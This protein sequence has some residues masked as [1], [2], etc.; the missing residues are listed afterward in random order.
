MDYSYIPSYSN[1]NT[2]LADLLKSGKLMDYVEALKKDEFVVLRHDVE[3]SI[4]RAYIMAQIE[5]KVGVKSS[6]FIQITNN[7]Y[8]A[9]SGKNKGLIHEMREMG[10]KIG[11]HYHLGGEHDPLKVRDGIRDQLR[12]MSEMLGFSIDRFSIHRPV[13]EVYYNMIP[14]DGIINAYSPEFFTLVNEDEQNLLEANKL[15]VKYIADSRHRWNY[16]FPDKET[17][18]HNKKVQLL[19]HPDFWSE[20]GLNAKENFEL[21]INEYTNEYI[22]TLDRECKHFSQYKIAIKKDMNYSG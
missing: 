13:R 8:N 22:E 20:K 2:I 11:L 21:L 3:F 10:H 1:Y 19:I 5:E 15:D 14:I 4:D 7:A 17:I 12:I 9:F 6:Y 16:G 18:I